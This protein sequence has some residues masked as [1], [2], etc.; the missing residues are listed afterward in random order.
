MEKSVSFTTE[1]GAEIT[2]AIV[3][4]RGNIADHNVTSACWDLEYTVNGKPT[5]GERINDPEIGAAVKLDMGHRM[6][7][8]KMIAQVAVAPIPA[9][10]LN[11]IDALIA[12]YM[13]GVN[14]ASGGESPAVRLARELTED[15]DRADSAN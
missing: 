11:E 13:A 14:A 4:E 3:T 6:D 7:G 2:I 10:R 5:F 12:E 9:D 1:R 15:M 8:R